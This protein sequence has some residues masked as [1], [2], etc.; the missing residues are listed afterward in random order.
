[1]A[2]TSTRGLISI[3]LGRLSMTVDECLE[4][5]GIPS[6]RIFGHAR[7][8]HCRSISF[9]NPGDKYDPKNLEKVICGV[10][11]QRDPDERSS[12]ELK[13]LNEDMCRT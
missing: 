7:W 6:E 2:G 8:F 12:T 1:M 5:Y 11:R 10:I 9:F 3:M 4:G 13:Q